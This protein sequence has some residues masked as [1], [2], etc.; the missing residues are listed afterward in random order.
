MTINGLSSREWKRYQPDPALPPLNSN[1][2]KA[3]RTPDPVPSPAAPSAPA[4]IPPD[5]RS[6]D[7]VETDR[8]VSIQAG[9]FTARTDLAGGGW[10]SIPGLGRHR[11][12]LDTRDLSRLSLSP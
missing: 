2:Q 1:A 11:P 5:A 10:R 6:G 12:A 3:V 8:V 4:V 7:F 9:H